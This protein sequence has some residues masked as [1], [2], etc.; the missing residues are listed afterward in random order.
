VISRPTRRAFGV[1][2]VCLGVS[3][4][5]QADTFIKIAT[6]APDSSIWT[7]TLREM[8]DGW[9][10]GTAGRITT[11]VQT[12]TT[13]DED[14]IVRHIRSG[15]VFQAGQI[16]AIALAHVDEA[17]SLFGIPMFFR[18]QEELVF[19][20]QKIGP[21]LERRL[22][23]KG[24]KV[25]HWGYAGWVHIFSRK[26][27]LTPDDLKK[28][29]LFTS[30]GDARMQTMYRQ[31]GFNPTPGTSAQMLSSLMTGMI[32]AMPA[33]PLA[34]QMFRW[35]EHAPYMMDLGF[36]PLIGATVI[37]V[38]TWR[39]IPEGDQKVILDEGKKAESRLATTVPSLER[40]AIG[41]MKASKG[42]IVN[43][44][45]TSEWG[46]TADAL[47]AA[48]RGQLVPENVYDAAIRERNAFRAGA[49]ASK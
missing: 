19:V 4:L 11:R 47:S 45:T 2:I 39:R 5:V 8:A 16:S 14:T 15:S 27:I 29:R 21:D 22:E 7:R 1:L 25:V 42:L 48:M 28:V 40:E 18:S 3:A 32:D 9:K 31:N 49:V 35:H 46:R 20:L 43:A 30:A 6:V 34:V 37:G 23:A 26:P 33:T 10:R 41:L 24:L 44:T 12:G 13:T 38:D 17:F 36:A